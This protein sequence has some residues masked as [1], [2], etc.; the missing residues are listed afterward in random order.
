ML[1]SVLWRV[2]FEQ[3]LSDDSQGSV[4]IVT[5][6]RSNG[7]MRKACSRV[8]RKGRR[9][10]SDSP[11]AR[12]SSWPLWLRVFSG[13]AVLVVYIHGDAQI[14]V[15]YRRRAND[16]CSVIVRSARNQ[17]AFDGDPRGGQKIGECTRDGNQTGTLE[18]VKKKNKK[19]QI[20]VLFLGTTT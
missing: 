16:S 12:R 6:G 11:D 10:Y 13:G 5:G 14:K 18:D 4:A 17:T 3:L 7:N 15:A 2:S 1:S 8:D 20:F 19:S 9:R